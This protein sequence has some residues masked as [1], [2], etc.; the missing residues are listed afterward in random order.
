VRGAIN[1]A[2]DGEK[3]SDG[4]RTGSYPN[5]ALI[6]DLKR[7]LDDIDIGVG[8]DE[9]EMLNLFTSHGQGYQVDC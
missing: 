4:R 3:L 7:R 8:E 6:D 5:Y 2:G 9:M 1:K